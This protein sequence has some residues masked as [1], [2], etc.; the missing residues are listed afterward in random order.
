MVKVPCKSETLIVSSI[1]KTRQ[2]EI[3]KP[4]WPHATQ[5]LLTTSHLHFK[6]NYKISL[7]MEYSL[8]QFQRHDKLKFNHG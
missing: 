8:L 1:S 6:L 3:K 4:R 5:M 7:S 2:I